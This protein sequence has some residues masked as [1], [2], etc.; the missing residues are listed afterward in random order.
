[1]FRNIEFQNLSTIPE[2]CQALQ[3]QESQSLFPIDSFYVN[4]IN[5]YS[6]NRVSIFTDEI[7]EDQTA[8]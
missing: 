2:L 3:K 4:F 6:D 5:F 7:G 8:E 1:M